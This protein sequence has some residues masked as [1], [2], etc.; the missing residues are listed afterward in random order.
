M[1]TLI[2]IVVLLGIIYSSLFFSSML[3]VSIESSGY[4]K[5]AI[6]LLTIV[7]TIGILFI[8]FSYND[9]KTKEWNNGTCKKCDKQY[10]LI[11]I[12]YHKNNGYSYFY[13]CPNCKEIH[14]FHE[15][16]KNKKKNFLTDFE[17][18]LTKGR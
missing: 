2:A 5:L 1:N 10:E 16:M 4:R 11:D 6:S 3:T 9:Y 7:F 13:Q 15:N 14:I 17:N 12:T 18:E 8:V